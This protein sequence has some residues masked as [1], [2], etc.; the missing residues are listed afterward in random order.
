MSD[1]SSVN[2]AGYLQLDKILD[3]QSP[4]GETDMEHDEHL[5][6]VIHQ[7]YELWFKQ[8]LHELDEVCRRLNSD[9]IVPAMQ[10][11]KR[12]LTILK[13]MVG[14]LDVLET[15][16][17]LEFSA[18]RE[19]LDRASG[20]QSFQFRE[21]EFL[22]GLKRDNVFKRYAADSA[23]YGQLKKRFGEPGLWDVFLQLL[24]RRGYPIPEDVLKRDVTKTIE[25]S[26]EVQNVIETVY[27]KDP[28]MMQVCERLTDLDEGVQEWR[29]RHIKMVQ[30]TIGVKMGT[31]GSDG[32]GYL[33]ATL[34][35]PF[36]PD[37]WDV[38]A[39]L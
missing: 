2:Y 6:I 32:A 11:L 24:S 21:F 26:I 30:R 35:A 3:A 14:Q 1:K 38:R 33:I 10:L 25:A 36:F 18:F 37:L 12:S 19:R 22:L 13:V 34:N 31:G 20:L 8:L 9:N 16:T 28:E 15:M 29:Y 17:P 39:V 5:F 7:V 4:R 27:R 23:E